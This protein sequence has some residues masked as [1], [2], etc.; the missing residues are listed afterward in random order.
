MPE[1]LSRSSLPRLSTAELIFNKA[2][3][4]PEPAQAAVLEMVEL[5]GHQPR[6]EAPA[7]IQPGSA[8]GL[9]TL[10]DGFDDPLPEFEPYMK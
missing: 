7:V 3:A 9:V 6:S 5:L 2:K 8:K 4:L 10:A 1:V